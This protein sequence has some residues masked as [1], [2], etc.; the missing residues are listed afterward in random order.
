MRGP[1]AGRPIAGLI[2]LLVLW[3]SLGSCTRPVAVTEI[4]QAITQEKAWLNTSRA[5]TPEDLKGR[6]LLLDFWTFACINCMHI[7]PDLK[8]LESEFGPDLSVIGV[9]S[10]KF[11]NERETGNIRAAILR[12]DIEHPVVN[13]A[14]FRIWK[15]FN[16]H[17]WPT[18]A[19][20][21][22]QGQVE[23]TLSGE[24]HREELREAI[25]RLRK[26][27][28]KSL[29]RDPLPIAFEKDKAPASVLSFPGKIDFDPKRKQLIISDSS[30]HRIIATDLQGKVLWSAGGRGLPGL[31]DGS[32]ANARFNRPQ[33]VLVTP[34]GLVLVA[35]TENHALRQI[36]PS[37]KTVV[38][39]AGTGT[40]GSEREAKDA[41]ALKTALSSPWDLSFAPGADV[42]V[43]IAMAGTHQLWSYDRVSGTLNVVA[44]NGR[45]SIEDGAYPGNSLSQ[46]SGLSSLGS[47]VY[48]LDSETSSLR[49][50][51]KS[52]ITTL[53][54]TGLFDFGFKDG[55]IG[56][57][58]MQHPLG[59]HADARGIWIADTFNHTIR[60]FDPG[61]K[62]LETVAGSGKSGYAD[63]P[64]A[65]AKF[66]EPGD[67]EGV[68]GRYFVADTNNHQIRVLD[69]MTRTVKTLPLD[70]PASQQP[71]Q[72]PLPTLPRLKKLSPTV[73]AFGRAVS[74]QLEL[75]P[76][77]KINDDAPSWLGIYAKQDGNWSLHREFAK[78]EL[79]NKVVSVPSLAQDREYLLQGTLY[80]CKTEKGSVCLIQSVE[81]TLKTS[82]EGQSHLTIELHDRTR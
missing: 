32:F 29:R 36:D 61:T 81:Q 30:H 48:V 27:A 9:H 45:E 20:I 22:P 80:Y 1:F 73:V 2:Y 44:G 42:Q 46:P 58:L 71:R 34:E 11:D 19:L 18:L 21:N 51:E 4:H 6:I 59:I 3:V 53:M 47:K 69:P 12:H 67:I 65:S 24:G 78:P 64:Y 7:I 40:Q 38:T 17:A 72:S 55:K 60:R 62:R 76:G 8:A 66:S 39:L 33:G 14:E 70:E 26:G 10:A 49:V 52:L 28:G 57:G 37:K 25:A 16:V 74:V 63:G 79:K 23:L 15:S 5:L 56:T 75:E 41:P 13:D 54:G 77:W 82:Q 43:M 68:E 35:D 31:A 50:L